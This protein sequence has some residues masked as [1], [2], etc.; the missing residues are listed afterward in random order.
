MSASDQIVCAYCGKRVH[1]EDDW[2]A[3][4]DGDLVC[5]AA[6]GTLGPHVGGVQVLSVGEL[7]ATDEGDTAQ[8]SSVSATKEGAA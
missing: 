1:K 3:D 8:G 6:D 4:D 7:I 2:W 5:E